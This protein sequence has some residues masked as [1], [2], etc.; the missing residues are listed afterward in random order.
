MY[1]VISTRGG[2]VVNELQG[3]EEIFNFSQDEINNG[4]ITFVLDKSNDPKPEFSFYVTAITLNTSIIEHSFIPFTFISSNVKAIQTK[5]I[6]VPPGGKTIISEDHLSLSEVLGSQK[7][8]FRITNPSKYGN[9]QYQSKDGGFSADA[10]RFSQADVVNQRILYENEK[11]TI[12]EL[13]KGQE[14]DDSFNFKVLSPN[15]IDHSNEY[16]FHINVSLYEEILNAIKYE[17][18]RLEEGGRAPLKIDFNAAVN[19]LKDKTTAS[20]TIMVKCCYAKNGEV[21]AN[22]KKIFDQ[23]LYID[24]F[25][26]YGMVYVHDHSDTI[27][28]EVVMAV[29]L[30][31]G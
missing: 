25:E 24:D 12:W 20:N 23:N 9:V 17:V 8:D 31:Q 1:T 22:E 16:S 11:S 15:Y 28:D 30:L 4:I 18:I 29:Y 19:Y 6:N 13:Q 3:K 14:V 10:G 27:E 21:V 7:M 2:F 26:Q 5:M